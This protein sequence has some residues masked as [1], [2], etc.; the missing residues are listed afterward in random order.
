M[1]NLVKLKRSAVA[2]KAPATTDLDLGELA[3]NTFDGKLFLKK[4]NGTA[5]IVE[6]GAGGGGSGTVTSVAVSGGTTGLTTSGGPIT[7]SGTITLAGTLAVASGGTGATDAAGARTGIGAAALGANT[8]TGAQNLADNELARPLLKDYAE[9]VTSPA[10]SSGTLTLNLEQGNVFTVSLNANIAT[11]TISNPP[12]SGRAGSF[13]LIFTADGTARAV[14]WG[15]AIQWPGGT[16]PTLTSAN[17][18]VDVL[19]FITTDGGTTWRG[20]VS[21]Q[22]Y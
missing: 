14:T 21:G 16:A 9:A 11:L 10:I 2:G 6:I 13:T 17:G 20:F 3:I 8:F 1:A 18:K 7:S 5:S 4:D 19:T 12:A 15:G 22:N